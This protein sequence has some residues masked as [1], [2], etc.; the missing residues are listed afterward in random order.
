[1]ELPIGGT[2][3]PVNALA[4][5]IDFLAIASSTPAEPRN[6]QR[7]AEDLDGSDTLKVLKLAREI[8]S[9]L[10]GNN[11]ESLGLHP[12]V[13]FYNERGVYTRHLFLGM[14]R[15]VAERVRNNDPHFFKKFT[16]VRKQLEEFLMTN[17][18]LIG[19]AFANVNR[20]A[21]GLRVRD[22]L[23]TLIKRFDKGEK[24]T[25]EDVFAS[26]GLGGQSRTFAS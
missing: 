12:A 10:A 4:L 25:T 18:S 11:A 21:R 7:D 17:K 3:S 24:F 19:R 1:M 14:A 13:Y 2:V 23:E 8:G 22:M 5:L 6:L 16:R 9:R 15:L 20:D 26:I